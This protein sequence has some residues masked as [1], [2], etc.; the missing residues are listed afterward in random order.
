MHHTTPPSP[1]PYPEAAEPTPSVPPPDR[2]ASPSVDEPTVPH[3]QA[4]EG[5]G[6]HA[7]LDTEP[8]I[9]APVLA[10]GAG[11]LKAMLVPVVTALAIGTA[12]VAVYLA[13]FHAP[14]A[15]HQPLGIAA[16]DQQ[17]ARAELALNDSAPDAYTFH[18][19]P[20]AAAARDAVAHDRVPAALVTEGNSTV[21]LAA[22][23]QGPSTVGSLQAAATAAAG[24]PV[25]VQDVVPLA[26]GDSRGLSVFY[27]AFGVVLAG[28]LFSVASYQI[29]PRL[30][31]AARV[32]S[33]VVFATASGTMVALI[34]HQALHALP[35]AFITVALIAG[36]LA[37]ATATAAGV[38]LRLFGPLGMPVASVVL[39]ILGNATSGGILP[40]SFLP[41]WLAPLAQIMPPAAA[42]RA[43]RGAGYYHSA[44]L[45]GGL[46]LLAAW[47]LGCLAVQ[48]VL[49]L[50]AAR[51]AAAAV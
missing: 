6:R 14:T 39:L 42:V 30:P 25:A 49:D 8:G 32:A 2:P 51:K 31:L 17:A 44:H 24:H 1:H 33:T 41:P 50:R 12:F 16:S 23:A 11:L 27:A 43:L 13:A 9:A 4:A 29:A 28:F 18:R 38:L 10:A 36:L 20:S 46:V 48:Y 45:T 3:P 21:L 47:I 37:M 34:G 26:S 40:P 35:A 22:G 15:H 19:Y 5:H 7:L